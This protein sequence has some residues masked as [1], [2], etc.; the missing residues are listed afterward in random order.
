M[1]FK[2]ALSHGPIVWAIELVAFD[3]DT[4]KEVDRFM[5]NSSTDPGGARQY[6]DRLAKMTG[7]DRRDELV[8]MGN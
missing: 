6:A 1:E 3:L 7:F 8:W 2:I 4:G 5:L